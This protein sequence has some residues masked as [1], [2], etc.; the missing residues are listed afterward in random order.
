MLDDSRLS[1]LV[2]LAIFLSVAGAYKFV[3]GFL[4][5]FNSRKNAWAYLSE[6]LDLAKSIADQPRTVF[7]SLKLLEAEI[8]G[9]VST[10]QDGILFTRGKADSDQFLVIPW[11]EMKSFHVSQHP[12]PEASFMLRRT[13]GLPLQVT[14]TWSPDF[15]GQVPNEFAF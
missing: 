13:S 2:A 5:A 8:F 15:S 1:A 9:Y 7:G 10:N 3:A 14:V 4:G 11:E 12:K 6:R